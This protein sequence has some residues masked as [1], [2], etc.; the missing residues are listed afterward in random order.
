MVVLSR[1]NRGRTAKLCINRGLRRFLKTLVWNVW[2]YLSNFNKLENQWCVR[3]LCC[4]LFPLVKIRVFLSKLNLC[5]FHCWMQMQCLESHG[6]NPPR[7]RQAGRHRPPE[8]KA[9]HIPIP[10]WFCRPQGPDLQRL[11][12]LAVRTRPRR[13]GPPRRTPQ[14]KM[15]IHPSLSWKSSWT[16][17]AKTKASCFDPRT[18]RRSDHHLTNT[19]RPGASLSVLV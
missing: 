16:S 14:V 9:V 11:D 2:W 7:R 3:V 5:G 4:L 8:R 10:R 12:F 13:L 17:F 1:N 19:Q 6:S 18:G 15:P